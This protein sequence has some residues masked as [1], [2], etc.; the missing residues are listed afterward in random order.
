MISACKELK[1]KMTNAPILQY[2][3]WNKTLILTTDASDKAIGSV[4]SQ[5]DKEGTEHPIAYA[6]RVLQSA[7]LNYST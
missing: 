2:P 3:D 7:E 6:S 5:R 4:L 1:Q